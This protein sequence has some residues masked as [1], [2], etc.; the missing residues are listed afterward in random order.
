VVFISAVVVYNNLGLFW[1]G[2][3]PEHE[4]FI[5]ALSILVWGAIVGWS[6]WI[7]RLSLGDLGFR[8]KNLRPSLARGLLAGGA[9]ATPAIA[10]FIFP[11]ILPQPVRHA[12]YA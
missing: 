8:R 9:M 11:V 12:G 6:I 4:T 7:E 3:A 5:N 2:R 10:F 1:K